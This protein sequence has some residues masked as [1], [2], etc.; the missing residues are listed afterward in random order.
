[1]T[2]LSEL[3]TRTYRD[4]ADEAQ[5]VFSTVQVEDF[6]RAGVAEL[7]RIAPID[8]FDD[9]TLADG[10][11]D[12]LTSVVLPYAVLLRFD[13]ENVNALVRTDDGEQITFGWNHRVIG[14]QAS[15]ELPK[16]W[17]DGWMAMDDTQR[18]GIRLYG[19]GNRPIPY[20]VGGSSTPEYSVLL[21]AV[22]TTKAYFVAPDDLLDNQS[23]PITLVLGSGVTD[24]ALRGRTVFE[25]R[26][27]AGT[28][29]L[30]VLNTSWQ[31]SPIEIADSIVNHRGYMVTSQGAGGPRNLLITSAFDL[32]LVGDPEV[33]LGGEE[34]FSVR[35]FAKAQG[36]DLLTHDRSLFAQWQGQTNNTDVSPV[37][38]LNMAAQAKTDWERRARKITT[39]RRYW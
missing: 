24:A 4:L 20:S 13:G 30:Y 15:L 34:E 22:A 23:H 37:M 21:D 18:P 11:T 29:V 6:V 7:N 14:S 17:V 31:A 36:F 19:Y 16:S 12:Y 8:T 5:H 35:E 1:M 33:S 9:I 38:M 3:V 10:I 39:V 28:G 2:A 32:A 27:T 25:V 26:S